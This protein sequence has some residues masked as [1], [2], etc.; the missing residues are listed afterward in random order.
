MQIRLV[1]HGDFQAYTGK[2]VEMLHLEDSATIAS[3]TSRLAATHPDAL[4]FLST[5]QFSRGGQ[6]VSTDA[7]LA[8]GDII[9]VCLSDRAIA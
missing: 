2:Q 5:L 3:L 1:Y 9:D 8:D 6:T 7:F 4:P